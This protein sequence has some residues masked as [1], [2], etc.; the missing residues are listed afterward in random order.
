MTE[1]L[2]LEPSDRVLEIGTGSGY[3]AAVLAEIVAE[4]YT[5][6]IL[7]DLAAGAESTLARLGYGNVHVRCGDGY[8]GW[9]EAAPFDAII[10][11]CAPERVPQPL[12]DQL[13]E[14]G[15]LVFPVAG[16]YPQMLRR[17][18]KRGGELVPEDLQPVMFVPMTGKAQD[19]NP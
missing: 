16:C 4:V 10:G 11:T 17:Y 12:F 2:M 3:Q 9:P 14:G 18:T 19:D 15:R 8:E 5:I 1:A 13:K 7:P 6:E